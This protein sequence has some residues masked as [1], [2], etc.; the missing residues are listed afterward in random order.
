MNYYGI[1][2]KGFLTPYAAEGNL[3][4][5][6]SLPEPEKLSV[7]LQA[8]AALR[9]LHAAGLIHDDVK[10]ANFVRERDGTVRMIDFESVCDVDD[11]PPTAWGTDG[12]NAPEKI[13][14]PET[15]TQASDLWSFG[16]VLWEM[17]D[18]PLDV[19]KFVE[20]PEDLRP[21]ITRLLE[22]DPGMRG[23]AAEALA[24]IEK[25]VQRALSVSK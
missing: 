16:L 21:L 20:T 25:F 23:T 14:A 18:E 8:A 3:T 4:T 11:V 24:D 19:W 1:L 12:Y 6:W 13:A 10:P 9:D 17:W 7:I 5:A 2:W 22:D 15:R